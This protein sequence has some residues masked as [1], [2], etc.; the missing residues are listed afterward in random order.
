MQYCSSQQFH[1]TVLKKYLILIAFLVLK[2]FRFGTEEVPAADDISGTEEG[3]CA[4]NAPG[5]EE[6][7]GTDGLPG[8]EEGPCADDSPG[9]EAVPEA[10]D[11]PDAD[12]ISGTEIACADD[13]PGTEEVPGAGDAPG[14]DGVSGIGT[15]TL[16]CS[17]ALCCFISRIIHTVLIKYTCWWKLDAFSQYTTL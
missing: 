6:V 13:L 16:M 12:D 3:P 14:T 11:V 7:P 15:G 10:E 5:T 2:N 9:T 17:L 1:C 8:I 4:D